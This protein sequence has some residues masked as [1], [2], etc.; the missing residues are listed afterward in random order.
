LLIEAGAGEDIVMI[1]NHTA[2]GST[3]MYIFKG[4]TAT[5]LMRTEAVTHN[6]HWGTLNERLSVKMIP[7]GSLSSFRQNDSAF[8]SAYDLT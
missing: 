6:A 1:G 5:S 4:T 8:N 2:A 7:L 3:P